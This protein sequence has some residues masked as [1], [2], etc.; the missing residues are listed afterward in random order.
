MGV[1]PLTIVLTD[2]STA[3][4]GITA[5]EWDFGDGVTSTLQNLTHTYSLFGS[6]SPRLTIQTE[7]EG[8]HSSSTPIVVLNSPPPT[9]TV[10]SYTYDGLYRLK[11]AVYSSGESVEYEYDAVGN[12]TA[13]TRTL[14]S[15]V[16]TTYTYDAAN[17]LTSVNG[18]AYTW[19][20]NGNLLNDGSKNYVY[21][22][23][24]RLTNISANGLAWSAAYNGDGAR[25]KQTSNGSVTTYTLDL[26]AGLVQVLAQQDVSGTTTYLYGVSRIG[27][28]QPG[29]WAYH[30]SDALGSVRQL[31]DG[32]AQVTLARGYMPY[33]EELWSLGTGTSA[34]GY[35]GEDWN[36][37]TQMVF[38]RARYMQPGLG[39]FLSHDPWS[40]DDLRP[41]SMNGWNYV[42][43]K[44]VN[45]TDPSGAFICTPDPIGIITCIIIVG[46][47]IITVLGTPGCTTPDKCP[48]LPKNLQPDALSDTPREKAL[49][50]IQSYFGI[51]LPPRTVTIYKNRTADYRFAYASSLVYGLSQYGYTPRFDHERW[52]QV[53]V[54][55]PT[56]TV[57]DFNAYDIAGFMVH[58]ATHAWQEYSIVQMAE[59]D[60]K[61]RDA[62]LPPNQPYYSE[63]WSVRYNAAMEIQAYEYT[64]GTSPTPI[65]LSRKARGILEENKSYYAG[66][67]RP[68]IPGIN[69]PEV[70][71]RGRPLP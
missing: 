8:G 22:Q 24:N 26:N 21:D 10:T 28:Q 37:T 33:G 48:A 62:N 34:Y 43:G 38:L 31:T 39:A 16:V 9:T 13:Y 1:A 50:D 12:R 61:F 11:R 51:K 19:D 20:A 32:S 15:Q 27:E 49:A 71:L 63:S 57:F 25:L 41:G 4:N 69:V 44:P 7:W 23:A 18:Q 67:S 70:G 65:C 6:Y 56:F 47:M 52:G 30:L 55:G 53:Y 40:G 42:E 35:T 54:Y 3:P 68:P 60:R 17:R 59:E 45:H 2:T 64:L 5:W 29:G 36:T 14:S 58:E 46:G 66:F